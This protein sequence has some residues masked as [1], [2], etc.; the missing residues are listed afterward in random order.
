VDDIRRKW[1]KPR[2][3]SDE[4]GI[5]LTKLYELLNR[6][7]LETKK[8]GTSRLISVE[9]LDR[10][11]ADPEPVPAPGGRRKAGNEHIEP[12]LPAD[13]PRRRGRPAKR[14]VRGRECPRVLPESR[15]ITPTDFLQSERPKSGSQGGT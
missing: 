10:L 12:P 8:I 15:Q 7:L 6:G 1:I 11:F 5:G 9:S 13:P 4:Y 3:T 2:R 14:I